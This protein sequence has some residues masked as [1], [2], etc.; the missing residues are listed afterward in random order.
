[1]LKIVTST[2]AKKDFMILLS[3]LG[4]RSLQI[5][6]KN[7]CAMKSKLP[8]CNLRISFETNCKL[9][10][11]FTFKDE[12]SVFLRSGIVYTFKCGS[13]NV[14]YYVKNKRYFKVRMCEHLGVSAFTGQKV[15]EINH[16]VIKEHHLFFNHSSSFEDFSI[17]ASNN[18]EFKVT[19]MDSLLINIDHPLFL[20]LEHLDNWRT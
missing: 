16:S 6:T 7:N 14:T 13:C 9:I 4:K 19:L 20:L 17:L 3:Y 10:N 11:L 1:M 12:F 15:K 8:Y 18:F 5:R 2:V